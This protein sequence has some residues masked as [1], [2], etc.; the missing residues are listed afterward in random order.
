[1]QLCVRSRGF[2]AVA[3]RDREA[4]ENR[5]AVR[6]ICCHHVVAVLKDALIT[7]PVITSKVAGKQGLVQDEITGIRIRCAETCV[8]PQERDRIKKLEC[9]GAIARSIR[10]VLVFVWFVYATG[11]ANLAIRGNGKGVLGEAKRST[12][13]CAVSA[14]GGIIVHVKDRLRERRDRP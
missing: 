10:V 7:R 9:S 6:T 4:I 13:R 3:R 5:S 14:W 11:D 8:S 1:M 12:P 2:E